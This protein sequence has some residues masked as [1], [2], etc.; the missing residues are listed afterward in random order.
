M[1][2]VQAAVGVYMSGDTDIA[3]GSADVVLASP[4]LDSLLSLIDHREWLLEELFLSFVCAFLYSLS[5]ILPA[6]G[7]IKEGK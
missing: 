2:V 5:A 1:A 6:A 7:A 4:T 3:K